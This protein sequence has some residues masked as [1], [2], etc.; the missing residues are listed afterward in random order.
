MLVTLIYILHQLVPRDLRE[1]LYLF[2]YLKTC[3]VFRDIFSKNIF[4]VFVTDIIHK[5]YLSF[6]E[7]SYLLE[8][9]AKA[10][11]REKMI[12]SFRGD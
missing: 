7:I 1:I 12:L 5:Y 4:F 11:I 6:I 3:Y 9:M 8:R 10:E 2:P